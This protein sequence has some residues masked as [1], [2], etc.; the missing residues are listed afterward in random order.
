[1][2]EITL[3]PVIDFQNTARLNITWNGA[4]GELPDRVPRDASDEELKQMAAE[5]LETGYVP[6][7]PEVQ[8]LDLT[9]YV[10][11]RTAPSAEVPDPYLF[12]T[13]KTPVG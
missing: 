5:A 6:G 13:P 2:N 11:H 4:N 1:M 7:I 10:V 8:D 3:F 12:V 9:H